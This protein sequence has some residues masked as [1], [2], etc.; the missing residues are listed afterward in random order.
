MSTDRTS[1]DSKPSRLRADASSLSPFRHP[2]FT[3]LWIATVVSNIGTWMQSAAAA[4][5]MTNLNPD[6][7][8]VA[9]VQVAAA[10]PMFIFALPAG[11]LADIVDRRRLLIGTQVATTLLAALFGV[12]VWLERV[13]PTSLLVL[14]FLLGACAALIA[15]TWQSIVPQ[16]VPRQDLQ[17]AVA[18][19]SVGFNVSRAVGPA[20]AG[21]IIGGWSLAA[22]F[23]I[24]ALATAGVIVALIW[25]HPPA[26]PEPHLPPERF[27]SAI[28]AGLRHARFN[29]HLRATLIRGS[30][31]FAIA[32]AYW[33]LL[34]LVARDQVKGGPALYGIL[35]GII[36]AAAVCGA[37]LL[38]SLKRRLG[39]DGV[40]VAGTIGT[41]VAMILYGLS[42]QPAAAIAASAIAG[43]S[44]IAVLATINVSA[45]VALPEWVRGRGLAVF[46]TVLF[47]ALAIGS[48]LW[49]QVASLTGL[50]L[51]HY[52]AAAAMIVAIPLLSRWKLQ[53][54]AGVD[55]TPSM[56]WPVP[57]LSP[58]LEGD[59]GPVLITIEYRVPLADRSEFLNAITSI[60]S[61]RRRDGA[62]D[63]DV[64][65]DA[66][67][68]GRFVEAYLV[69][70]WMEHLRQHDRVTNAD[71]V[72]EASI[73]RFQV[74]GQPV[75]THWLSQRHA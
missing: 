54:G 53:T 30:S 24:N 8:I 65:E 6:P 68:P 70:S 26:A 31:F 28:R 69:D 40:V 20:L 14:T 38:P 27:F 57:V 13:T 10:L 67:E 23:W 11:A 45:Q 72:I 34:P 15:P 4:W 12:L 56:H 66:A 44:W 1:S 49:G 46:V 18:L 52:L 58:E 36:G 25:W 62:Y 64:Y 22:P 73:R 55:L 59:R 17:P 16:L 37:F 74:Q 71:K 51:A 19:N 21:L 7:L 60:A 75:V 39:A 61:I 9:L 3:V 2:A 63:W 43:M 42:Q 5:L 33:A 41:A 35:L 29:P 32:S 47:G 48:V 50:P